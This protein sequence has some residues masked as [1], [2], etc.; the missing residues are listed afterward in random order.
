MGGI[1]DDTD[2]DRKPGREPS[3]LPR[4]PAQDMPPGNPRKPDSSSAPDTSKPQ[5]DSQVATE[6]RDN[7]V[8][9]VL[10]NGAADLT[11]SAGDAHRFSAVNPRFAPHDILAGRYEIVRFI[12]RGA[13][14][15]V[16]EAKD[17]DLH[18]RVA[19]KI[20]LPQ[21]ASDERALL[22][23]K[24]EIQLARKVTHPN[25]C[26]IFDVAY[27]REPCSQP[28]TVPAPLTVFLTMELLEGETL[29]ERLRRAGRMT[30][31]E[32]LPI[33]EQVAAGLEA[34]H[35]AG[36]IHRDFKTG[37]VMLVPAGSA[38]RAVVT[39]FGLARAS[40]TSEGDWE[41]LTVRDEIVGT[42]EYM[43]PEQVK[44]EPTSPATDIYALGVVMY[45]MV[46]GKLP[47]VGGSRRAI[48]FKRLEVTP[49]SPRQYAKHLDPRWEQA[50]LRCLERDP[51]D[52]FSSAGDVVQALHG[53]AVSPAS[54]IY[55]ALKRRRPITAASLATLVLLGLVFAIPDARLALKQRLGLVSIPQ[56]KRLAVLPFTVIG[57][58]ADDKAFA[59]GVMETLTAKLTRL[60]GKHSL[61]VVPAGELTAE[62]VTSA[63]QARKEFGVNLALRGSLQRSGRIIRV[64]FVLIDTDT[65][66]E[67]EGDTVDASAAD[68]FGVQDRVVSSVVAMLEIGPR[69]ERALLGAYGTLHPGAYDYYLRGLGYLQDYQKPENVE[70]AIAVFKEALSLDPHYALAFAGLG[71]AYWCQYRLTKEGTWADEALQACEGA[72]ALQADLAEAHSCLGTV[73]QGTGQYDKAIEEFQSAAKLDPINDE[74]HRGLAEA[75]EALGRGR[76]A[77]SAYKQ[78]IQLRPQYWGGY[79]RLGAFYFRKAR[80]AEAL[81]LFGQVIRLAPDN[82]RGYS[83]LGGV[84]LAQARYADAVIPLER[85]LALQPTADACSNLGVAYFQLRRF[86][87]SARTFEKAAKLNGQ[88]YLTWG[89]LGD[90]Y[91]WTPGERDQAASAYEKAVVLAQAALRVNPHDAAVMADLADYYSMQGRKEDALGFLGRALAL[92]PNEPEL[93][94]K[95]AEVYEQV[96]DR[97]RSIDWLQK[98]RAAGYSPTI[99]RDTPVL[100]NL[101]SDP[102]LKAVLAGK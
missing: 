10:G 71:C 75:Y 81:D 22:R 26:R 13:M 74:A 53:I 85:S 64:T 3:T 27:H 88:N 73:Y 93:M 12:G 16:Y 47:F 4:G 76:E 68:P 8:Q 63:E 50:I 44:G 43:A 52:R 17:N 40:T 102:R 30:I 99:I 65:R 11:A 19:L 67:L 62:G 87:D 91:Y 36:V 25:V 5:D 100:D 77:E 34:E 29:L 101:R 82:V 79:N 46:T 80:Y 60:E 59:D 37:N 1:E 56:D 32:A 20:I 94:F 51:G 45:A 42:P 18:V 97:S 28:D 92:N 78:A 55:Q 48:A 96:G 21:I 95:A 9:P 86:S 58:S 98:A 72:A 49:A 2:R 6:V 61:H 54:H 70:S 39:D 41:S 89:N 84:Y 66:Q 7:A 31:A 57:G 14:G 38:V 33:V 69:Q 23:F 35:R 24:R 90:A 83:N 15:E